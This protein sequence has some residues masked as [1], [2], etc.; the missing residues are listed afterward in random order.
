MTDGDTLA[1]PTEDT[2]DRAAAGYA[3]VTMAVASGADSG[4]AVVNGEGPSMPFAATD[5]VDVLTRN[6][7]VD[8]NTFDARSYLSHNYRTLR[9]D[10]R[11]FIEVI[12]DFFAGCFANQPLPAV[13][14]GLDLGAGANLYPAFAMLPFVKDLTLLDYSESNV[15]YL[16]DQ[17]PGF[18][19]TWEPFWKTLE[20]QAAVYGA[21]DPRAELSQKAEVVLGDLFA[22][23][24]ERRYDVGTM[25]FVAESISTSHVEFRDAIR[26]FASALQ[27][28]APFA[29]GFMENSEGYTVGVEDFPAVQVSSDEIHAELSEVAHG[30]Q[31]YCEKAAVVG[32]LREG[33]EGMVLVVGR[34]ND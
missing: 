34:M 15:K 33:Y 31:I 26:K 32:A 23:E 30:L 22:F 10:D 20:S 17:L 29:A 25:F 11:H 19:A 4:T 6:A 27:P 14:R 5:V 21:V 9:G 13:A 7:D 3:E 12:A 1:I 24:P 28:G 16:R 18:D 8:W 2:Q